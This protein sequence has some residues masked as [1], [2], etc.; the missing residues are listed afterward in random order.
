MDKVKVPVA[1]ILT[2]PRLAS[3]L[4]LRALVVTDSI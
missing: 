2:W 4:H 3:S 1:S